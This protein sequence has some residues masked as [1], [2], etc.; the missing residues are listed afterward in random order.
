MPLLSCGL[1]DRIVIERSIKVPM[2]HRQGTYARQGIPWSVS[3]MMII[4][5]FELFMG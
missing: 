3:A 2:D 1:K 5:R 4:G